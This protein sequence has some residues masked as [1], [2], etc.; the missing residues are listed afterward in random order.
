MSNK[1]MLGSR[2]K[3]LLAGVSDHGVDHLVEV[4]TDLVQT[5][6][7]LAE[8]IEKLGAN[9]LDLHGSLTAQEEHIKEIVSAGKVPPESVEKLA[10]IGEVQ[11]GAGAVGAAPAPG[12]VPVLVDDTLVV[13]DSLAIAEYLAEKYPDLNLWPQNRADRARA[14]SICA[15]MHGGFT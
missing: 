4:E 2:V 13:W 12:K 9:F 10:Q 14:R 7:L 1:Q 11:A 6:L 5:T 15:E 8:A 3:E